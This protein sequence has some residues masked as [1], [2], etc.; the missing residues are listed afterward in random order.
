[1]SLVVLRAVRVWPGVRPGGASRG[2]SPAL[3]PGQRRRR[4]VASKLISAAIRL[5]RWGLLE[6]HPFIGIGGEALKGAT[7]ARSEGWMSTWRS[8]TARATVR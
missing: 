8:S 5:T 3:T 2:Q 7:V 6:R 1:M 4:L